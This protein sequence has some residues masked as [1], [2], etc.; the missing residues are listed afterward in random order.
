MKAIYHVQAE[1]LS[2]VLLGPARGS[3]DLRFMNHVSSFYPP[4]NCASIFLL[5]G[6]IFTRDHGKNDGFLRKETR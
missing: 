5:Q 2:L 3:V 4:S 1:G 6:K